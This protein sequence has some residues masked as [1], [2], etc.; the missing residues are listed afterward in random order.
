M[1]P[2]NIALGIA[3]PFLAA[4]VIA[5]LWKRSWTLA[6][7]IGAP[8]IM[9]AVL[10]VHIYS[11]NGRIRFESGFFLLRAEVLKCGNAGVCT[12]CDRTRCGD[13]Y[14]SRTRCI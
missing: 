2:F 4:I 14:A 6:I 10:A 13:C 1:V 5:M 11:G 7:A 8:A 3:A 9:M 12:D